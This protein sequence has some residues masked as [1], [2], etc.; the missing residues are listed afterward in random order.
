MINQYYNKL[1]KPIRDSKISTILENI[2]TN[3][4][5]PSDSE[6]NF[7]E[8]LAVKSELISQFIPWV[9]NFLNGL[10]AFS[11]KYIANGN[12]DALNMMFMKKDFN[13]VCFLKNEYS[14]YPHLCKV[15]NIEYLELK[16]S[17]INLVSSTDL[18]LISL[19]SSYDGSASERIKIINQ[20]QQAGIQLFIDIAY[21]GLTDPFYLNLTSTKNTVVSFTFS[22]SSSLAYN[23]IALMFSDFEIPSL[24]IM[25]KIGYVNLAG[26]N[27]AI[28][29]MKSIPADYFY[30]NYK[31]QYEDICKSQNI[32]P[33]K[34]ILFGHDQNNDKFC[35]TPYYKTT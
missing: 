26:A 27:A 14:Y 23:R 18:F 30:I 11:Y 7:K 29:I 31:D 35:T 33:T 16:P 21:C 8:R 22:K 32:T 6:F 19:P 28:A 12:S 20:L 17:Q 5:F 24:E 34:C 3:K 15:L 10:S 4:A 25:N 13:R 9:G 2:D 1:T